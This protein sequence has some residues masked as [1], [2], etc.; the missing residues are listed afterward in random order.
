M[1]EVGVNKGTVFNRNAVCFDC[2]NALRILDEGL[3][4]FA[5]K[6]RYNLTI[7]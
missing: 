3:D 2:S 1:N 4:F 6:V 5:I 7:S